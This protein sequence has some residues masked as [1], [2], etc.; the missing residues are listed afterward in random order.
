MKKNIQGHK[1]FLLVIVA[2][3]TTASSYAQEPNPT[4]EPQKNSI[5]ELAEKIKHTAQDIGHFTAA[6]Y[7]ISK[8]ESKHFSQEAQELWSKAKETTEK[9]GKKIKAAAKNLTTKMQKSFHTMANRFRTEEQII[10]ATPSDQLAQDRNLV[11]VSVELEPQYDTDMTSLVQLGTELEIFAQNQHEKSKDDKYRLAELTYRTIRD[12]LL[13]N[14]IKEF[15][16]NFFKKDAESITCEI[17]KI[18]NAE[19]TILHVYIQSNDDV[20]MWTSLIERFMDIARMINAA[21]EENNADNFYNILDAIHSVISDA[22]ESNSALHLY[23]LSNM[24]QAPE[25]ASVDLSL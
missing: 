6:T 25:V 12:A 21:Q 19:R 14:I 4:A 11:T 17:N 5:V 8:E 1:T 13:K 20:V 16:I 10:L 15:S 22:I 9:A 2:V 23:M 7:Q 24:C 18:E 3:C